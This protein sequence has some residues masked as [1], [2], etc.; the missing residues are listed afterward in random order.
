MLSLW[1]W[2]LRKNHHRSSGPTAVG[3]ILEQGVRSSFISATNSYLDSDTSCR[4][5]PCLI[6]RTNV[7][8]RR[9]RTT[10]G[11]SEGLHPC[12][13]LRSRMKEVI[14]AEGIQQAM[15]GRRRHCCR[16]G[17][18]PPI[19]VSI[20]ANAGSRSLYKS[21]CLDEKR[22]GKAP[23]LVANSRA[24]RTARHDEQSFSFC[25]CSSH[26]FRSTSLS[27]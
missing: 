13:C 23:F 12:G 9:I 8:P 22:Q 14:M 21:D 27:R 24:D 6:R 5:P 18:S 1:Q 16:S 10:V 11:T 26:L 7:C 15:I 25:F 17:D 20:T 3:A 19:H 2:R 4:D